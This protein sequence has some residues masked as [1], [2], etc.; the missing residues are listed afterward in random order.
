MLLVTT[1]EAGIH[2][3]SYWR[4]AA[5]HD[6]QNAVAKAVKMATMPCLLASI[7]GAF[8]LASLMTSSLRPVYDFGMYSAIGSLIGYVVTLYGL[9]PLLSYLPAKVAL[10]PD[11]SRSS[12]F[13][14]RVAGTLVRR[15][16]PACCRAGRRGPHVEG[17]T[18]L[19]GA[20]RR[21]MQSLA[22][23]DDADLGTHTV[24][25]HL[26]R[27]CAVGVLDHNLGR[28]CPGVLRHVDQ[29][30]TGDFE[31]VRRDIEEIGRAHV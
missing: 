8:G 7:T 24:I 14:E 16:G 31:S 29:Q 19:A 3:V 22:G 20:G 21:V 13:W 1:M 11:D 6:P 30:L 9:P 25:G 23:G 12:M 17:P 15:H 28:R 10:G 26:D 2:V 5:K 27:Q 4:Y 18:V